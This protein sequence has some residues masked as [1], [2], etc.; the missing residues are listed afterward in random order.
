MDVGLIQISHFNKYIP[1]KQCNAGS[2][3]KILFYF[4]IIFIVQSLNCILF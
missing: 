4:G 2:M 1:S 3:K